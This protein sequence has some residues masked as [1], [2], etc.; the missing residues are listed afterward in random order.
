MP[1]TKQRTRATSYALDGP[2]EHHRK[3]T[4]KYA[5]KLQAKIE[6][7]AM[8]RF[9]GEQAEYERLMKEHEEKEA[10]GKTGGTRRRYRKHRMTRRR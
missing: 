9:R 4:R 6:A 2:L 7:A 3:H 10:R 1:D 5:A 8:K